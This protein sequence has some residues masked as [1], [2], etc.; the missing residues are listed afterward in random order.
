MTPLEKFL[1]DGEA[2]EKAA[3]LAEQDPWD[4]SM[5]DERPAIQDF[6]EDAR[7]RVGRQREIIRVL[8]EALEC[9]AA[10]VDVVL[11]VRSDRASERDAF[12]VGAKSI[13]ERALAEAERIAGGDDDQG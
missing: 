12:V 9:Y 6:V 10:Q 1:A 4:T 8:V 7:T 3:T 11:R 2:L 13:A 5:L